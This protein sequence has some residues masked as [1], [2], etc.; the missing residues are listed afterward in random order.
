MIDFPK[1]DN[2]KEEIEIFFLKF[3]KIITEQKGIDFF[4]DWDIVFHFCYFHFNATGFYYNGYTRAYYKE[5]VYTLTI[6]V[7][8]DN[9][10]FW[11]VPK[12]RNDNVV[13]TDKKPYLLLPVNFND[14]SNEKDFIIDCT[15]RSIIALFERG[16]TIRGEKLKLNI[17]NFLVEPTKEKLAL[18]DGST[19]E[20][21]ILDGKPHGKGKLLFSDG[22][23]YEGSFIN[24]K[25]TRGGKYTTLEGDEYED[26]DGNY[27]V[28]GCELGDNTQFYIN[29]DG[30]YYKGKIY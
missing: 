15:K 14:F 8:E 9:Q 7:P 13:H 18:A 10:V 4:P 30:T 19:Y 24:G 12:L 1:A 5:K 25:L 29:D 21:E 20:G 11:G 2:G 22:D 3:S 16:I 28:E 17:K 27:F 23:I 6:P 26:E